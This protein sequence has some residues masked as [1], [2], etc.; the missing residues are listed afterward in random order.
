M[1]QVSVGTQYKNNFSL[2]FL[3]PYRIMPTWQSQ[4]WEKRS[5]QSDSPSLRHDITLFRGL[6]TWNHCHRRPSIGWAC[7]KGRQFLNLWY[8]LLPSVKLLSYFSSPLRKSL[9]WLIG[10][11]WAR[12]MAATGQVVTHALHVSSLWLLEAFMLMTLVTLESLSL[13][14]LSCK[15]TQNTRLQEEPDSILWIA[16]QDG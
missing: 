6:L 1:E 4:V 15:C 11:A 7:A 13:I 5:R 8:A 3:S 10:N 12:R 16:R 2:V 14:F 9:Q